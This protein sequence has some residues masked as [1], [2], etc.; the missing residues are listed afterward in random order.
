M[1]DPEMARWGDGVQISGFRVQ[2]TKRDGY[3]AKS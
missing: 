3:D 1:G 2:I